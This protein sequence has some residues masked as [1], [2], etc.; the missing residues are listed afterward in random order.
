VKRAGLKDFRFH[1]LRHTFA[2][3]LVMRG[4]PLKEVQELLGHSSVRMSERYS[5][6]SPKRLRDA[7]ATLENFSTTSAQSSSQPTPALA[8]TRQI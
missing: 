4:R 1:D 2:S 6:L 5:H 7:V 8:T 3:Q